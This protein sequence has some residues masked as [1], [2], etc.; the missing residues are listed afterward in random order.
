VSFSRSREEAEVF[1]DWVLRAQVPQ[2]KLLF[3]PGL[4]HGASLRGEAEVLALGGNYE[5][6]ARYD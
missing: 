4:L 6:E 1:G 5:V 2:A 3:V